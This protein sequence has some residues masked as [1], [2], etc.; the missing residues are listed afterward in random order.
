MRIAFFLPF[1]LAAAVFAQVQVP[2]ERIRKSADEPGNW[3]THNGSYAGHRH[4]GLDQITPKNVANLKPTWVFQSRDAGKWE[5]TPLVVDGV[6]YISE[7]PNVI[8]A[9]DGHTGRPIWN[10]RRPLPTDVNGC[11]G[12]V[13]RGV[14][15]L[16][17]A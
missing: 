12:P 8:T 17:D 14:A 2:F 3:L 7:R 1:C 11:C 16:G 10:Y 9:L 13:N 5:C 15:I 4:S 6:L